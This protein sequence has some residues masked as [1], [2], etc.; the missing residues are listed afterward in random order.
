[1]SFFKNLLRWFLFA[2]FRLIAPLLP[3]QV[4]Y[5]IGSAGG[6]LYYRM[7]G[8]VMKKM[9]AGFRAIMPAEELYDVNQVMVRTCRNYIQSELEVFLYGRMNRANIDRFVSIEGVEHIDQAL[10]G[11]KGVI[12]LH[13]HFGNAHM[14]MPGLGHR[15]YKVNQVGLLPSDSA[16]MLED[17]LYRPPDRLVMSWFKLKEECEKKLPVKFIYLG[18]GMRPAIECLKRNELLAI[19]IDGVDG[20][21]ISVPFLRGKALFMTG[22]ARLSVATGAAIIPIFT[23][24]KTSG[25]HRLVIEPPLKDDCSPEDRVSAF[26][27]LLE[28]YMKRFPCH[29]ARLLG[30]DTPPF[31]PGR[32]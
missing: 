17:V 6:G 12:L 13:A 16:A 9:E 28:S 26:A 2:P 25:R 27:S 10:A 18:R 5:C 15:G 3:A 1:M 11:G 22:P 30:Y 7:S 24:R 21:M 31:S 29:Y 19:S 32:S 14:L 23:V 4:L 20:E 8:R